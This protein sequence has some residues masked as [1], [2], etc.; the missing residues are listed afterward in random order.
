MIPNRYRRYARSES[1]A[2]SDGRAAA[3]RNAQ[4]RRHKYEV[5]QQ[6][7]YFLGATGRLSREVEKSLSGSSFEISRLL[8]S[9]GAEFQYRVKNTTT[10]QERVVSE[11]DISPVEQFE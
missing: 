10:G 9:S 6:V 3:N 7:R 4:A 1:A 5:G 2:G 11:G 8:P